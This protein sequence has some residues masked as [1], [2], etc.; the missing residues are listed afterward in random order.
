MDGG[1]LFERVIND[2]FVLSEKACVVVIKQICQAVEFIHSKNILHLD[3]KVIKVFIK[4]FGRLYHTSLK[5]PKHTHLAPRHGG[6]C[7][8]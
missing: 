8:I 3:M 1:E 2:D 6:N 7:D 4:A 5:I